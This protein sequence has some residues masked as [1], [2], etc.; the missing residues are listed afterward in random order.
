MGA[1]DFVLG[2]GRVLKT[3]IEAST[4]AVLAQ[5]SSSIGSIN[6]ND[7]DEAIG[8]VADKQDLYGG[9]ATFFRPLPPEKKNGKAYECDVVYA[10]TSDGLVPLAYR[11]LR[12]D[13][14]FP[15]GPKE[16]SGGIRGY[17]GG[18]YTL[19]LTDGNS[20]SQRA[21][22]HVMYAPYSFNGSGV[23]QKAHAII[24]DTTS[25]NESITITHGEGYQLALTKDDGLLALI[26]SETFMR[27]KPG[28][29]LLQAPAIML[30]GLVYLGAQAEAGVPIVPGVT[31]GPSVYL[32]PV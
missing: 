17:G 25:G 5:V 30:K 6:P 18:F 13:K 2:F 19:D 20:G 23:P 28:E 32:S 14:A 31:P 1:L 12:L 11:D 3:S 10:K 24:L 21:N 16:G 26:D 9:G 29:F 15:S 27:A 8:E 4:G 22:I 7:G